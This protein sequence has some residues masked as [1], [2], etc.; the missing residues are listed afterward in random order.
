[1]SYKSKGS[2][3]P[4]NEVKMPCLNR[5]TQAQ[6]DALAQMDLPN[7]GEKTD[8]FGMIC[9]T[10]MEIFQKQK[11]HLLKISVLYDRCQLKNQPPL[12]RCAPL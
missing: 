12:E 2:M 8:C 4:S 1:M 9:G 7:G 11:C 10:R 3:V 6:E 5:K